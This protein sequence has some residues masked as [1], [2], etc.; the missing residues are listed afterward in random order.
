MFEWCV[1]RSGSNIGYQNDIYFKEIGLHAQ[2]YATHYRLHC[3][4]EGGG[5]SKAKQVN[6]H[7]NPSNV[8]IEKGNHLRPIYLATH[9]F[10]IS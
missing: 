3:Q 10:F 1:V 6:T 8:T 4:H 2:K 9:V 7:H 5:W